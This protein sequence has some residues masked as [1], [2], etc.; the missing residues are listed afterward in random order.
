MTEPDI[1]KFDLEAIC[2]DHELSEAVVEYVR[3]Q[4]TYNRS[5]FLG[6]LGEAY[7]HGATDD[8]RFHFMEFLDDIENRIVDRDGK[9]T[10]T[11]PP[12]EASSSTEVGEVQEREEAAPSMV[13]DEKDPGTINENGKLTK[14]KKRLKELAEGICE[15][16]GIEIDSRIIQDGYYLTKNHD[17]PEAFV[18]HVTE[19]QLE[20]IY[21]PDFLRS[22]D[23]EYEKRDINHIMNYILSEGHKFAPYDRMG[24]STLKPRLGHIRFRNGVLVYDGD[25]KT[26]YSYDEYKKKYELTPSTHVAY[27]IDYIPDFVEPPE[28]KKVIDQWEQGSLDNDSE[29]I[30][31]VYEGDAK[32]FDPNL[33]KYDKKVTYMHGPTHAGKSTA[34]RV[35]EGMY[36]E[37]YVTGE[38]A[39]DIASDYGGRELANHKFINLCSDEEMITKAV[40]R[41]MDDGKLKNI[42]KHEARRIKVKYRV[43][44]LY[45]KAEA[46]FIHITNHDPIWLKDAALASRVKMIKFY[47]G[48]DES[49]TDYEEFYLDPTAL[50]C[51]IHRV[52]PHC[53]Y[54]YK[55]KKSQHTQTLQSILDSTTHHT[56]LVERFITAK[57]VRGEGYKA[58]K[59]DT[60]NVFKQWYNE[61]GLSEPVLSKVEFFN[62]LL[63]LP[64]SKEPL[65]PRIDNDG[66]TKMGPRDR[67]I[68]LR[69]IQCTDAENLKKPNDENQQI[70]E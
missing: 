34:T 19:A 44:P 13:R 7:E 49:D 55:H 6:L 56:P 1:S 16:H 27:L 42:W 20:A 5:K 29:R 62:V 41:K 25:G 63:S 59:T 43:T 47:N 31:L 17:G 46:V 3:E 24:Q 39:P 22:K 66:S 68:A 33:W 35:L 37:D 58:P 30:T 12:V 36:G 11:T 14:W 28:Y 9:I 60:Y 65:M 38:S 57:C 45:V 53:Q 10:G 50:Q 61:Q 64:Y 8:D 4:Q 48:H 26:F 51:M 32:A 40:R 54:L 70:L 23:I 2:A 15:Y 67:R 52:I 69:N 21:I 18:K